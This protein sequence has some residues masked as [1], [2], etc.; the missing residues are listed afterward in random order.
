MNEATKSR[1]TLWR[2]LAPVL[3]L[4]VAK[5]ALHLATNGQYGFHR[6]E[7]A[8][9]D[10]ARNL[11][12]GFPAYGPVTPFV[13]RI[14]YALFGASVNA[15]RFPAALAQSGVIL[16]V[17]L[18]ARRLGAGRWTQ[19]LA[20]AAMAVAPIG[21]AGSTLMQYFSLDLLWWA[22]VAY[23][24]VRLLADDEPRWWLAV[25]AFIGLG[26]MTR[27]T[28]LFLATGIAVG[29][30]LTPARRYL[31]SKWLWLGVGVS[32]L[33]LLPNAIWQIRHN[34]ISIDCIREFHARD[35]RI[36]RA[37]GFLW[38]QL[39]LGTYP[40][41]PPLALAGLW[42]Y[43]FSAAGRRFRALGWM[44]LTPLV[45]LA[46]MHGRDY[47]MGPD[48]PVLLA[49]GAV[50]WAGWLTRLG[51]VWRRAAWGVSW[52]S[53]A[54]GGLLIALV[55]L[56]VGAVHG[57]IWNKFHP[58]RGDFY[59]EIGWE[60]LVATVAHVR[61]GLGAE[62]RAQLGVLAGNY[63]EAGALNLYGPGYG[64][65]RAMS[66]HFSYCLRGYT[67]PPPRTVICVGFS[68]RY[69][70]RHFERVELAGHI[71]NRYG[72]RNEEA[73]DHPDVYVCHNLRKPW[74]EFWKEFHYFD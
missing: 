51:P 27:Y 41:V 24:M 4:I 33:I 56:P 29:V 49:A 39:L 64:L 74:P 70:E 72:V 69:L 31:R 8:T 55:L 67:E 54:L 22:C 5:L 58:D 16:L 53:L 47:Y 46:A 23:S 73:K 10:D 60:E 63:G 43:L 14:V 66:G 7:L 36:G 45:L 11:D 28:I 40:F 2:D 19:S 65:P 42:F 13:M 57:H 17:A 61:D 50:V 25:G 71:T 52:L 34:F 12:W 1:G 44:F 3:V 18:M 32:L 15:L 38:K 26:M 37:D 35:V 6:D 9:L 62:D 20:A 48:Y 21:V 30:L 59:D 68:R